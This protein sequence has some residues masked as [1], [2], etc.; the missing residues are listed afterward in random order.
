MVAKKYPEQAVG[1]VHDVALSADHAMQTAQRV[2]NDARASVHDGARQLRD[3]ALRA[4][5]HS[6]R[7]VRHEPVKAVLIAAA[8]GAAVMA[9]L[10]AL[11]YA[12]FRD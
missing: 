9:L 1:L 2:A 6:V 12:L 11:G 10:S 4:S 5:D 7:F 3:S 8:A